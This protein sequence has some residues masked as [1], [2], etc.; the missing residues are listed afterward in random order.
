M[1]HMQK[2]PFYP[3]L[4]AI[5]PVLALYA[6]NIKEVS[7]SVVWRLLTLSLAGAVLLFCIFKLVIRNW[8]K[9]ALLTF[10]AL[11]IFFTYGRIYDALKTTSLV[12]LNI[13]RHRYLVIVFVILFGILSW[14]ILRKIRNFSPLT[15]ILNI[16]TLVLL[17][18]PVTEIA[19]FNIRY[20]RAAPVWTPNNQL[21]LKSQTTQMPDVYYIILDS[22][23]RADV[24][25]AD[26]G[27]DN[28][29][30]IKKLED[31]GFY[32]A[33]C[34]RSNYNN[35]IYSMASSLNIGYLPELIAEGADNKITD[36]EIW[37]M[38]PSLVRK[39]FEALGYK[40]VAFDTGFK[41]TSLEDADL[42]ITRGENGYGVQFISP[43]EHMLI[44]STALSIYNDYLIKANR[45]K[46]YGA[47]N[48]N[49]NYIGL[50]EFLLDQLPK[51]P[52]ISDPT[53]TY[54][55]INIAH[56]PYVFSPTGYLVDPGEMPTSVSDEV[57]FP[58]GYIHAIDYLNP[59]M[60]SIIQKIIDDSD[61]P[62]IIILQGDHGFPNVTTGRGTFPI[63]NA[64]YLPGIQP[65]K[66]YRTISPVNTF[67]L[68]FDEYYS[69]QYELL[70]DQSFDFID[71]ATPI[72]EDYTD[73]Q[74]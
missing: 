12:D 35:T 69:G 52:Q 15:G 27:Y 1:N 54:A 3:L 8:Q 70:P 64:Y 32:V 26:L 65:G 57:H 42:Y 5:Y 16:S 48:I 49:A 44:D 68:I 38:K 17:F 6:Y 61:V 21:V 22:Y 24:L 4:F 53:F 34:S 74:N 58:L 51:I 55:H 25:Q 36:N 37:L 18:I 56:H 45:V 72:A 43:F 63:L 23:T 14:V 62:P 73:C 9:S 11:F 30:F 50:E 28:S 31:L 71:L 20:G 13:V 66:L 33:T 47:S 40:T 39:N 10:T 59:R 29:E 60:L 46:Y 7:G 41:W 67:R 2:F 19:V